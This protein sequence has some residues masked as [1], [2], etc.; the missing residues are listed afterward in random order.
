MNLLEC[1]TSIAIHSLIVSSC[2]ISLGHLH[3]AYQKQMGKQQEISE[4]MHALHIMTRSIRQAGFPIH[5]SDFPKIKPPSKSNLKNAIEVRQNSGLNIH[6]KGEFI[7]RKGIHAAQDSD[8]IIIR[9]GSLGHFDCLGHRIT[10][11]RLSQGY[12]LQ[13]FFAQVQGTGKDRTGS[14]MCQS[15]DNKGRLQNDSILTGLKSL[16]IHSSTTAANHSLI[17]IELTM[18]SGQ[19]YSRAVMTRHAKNF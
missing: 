11:E 2:L 1:T 14:L 4:V 5:V 9:H 13:G 10:K 19:T 18:M 17:Q 16:K 3:K 8:A 12:A 7:Y 15:L 6:N